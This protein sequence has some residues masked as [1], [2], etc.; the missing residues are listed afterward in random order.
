M[1]PQISRPTGIYTVLAAVGIVV[2]I[3]AIMHGIYIA[4]FRETAM[5]T[6]A[7]ITEIHTYSERHYDSDHDTVYHD[8]YVAFEIDD[9]EYAGKL[10][11]YSSGMKEG[12]KV[13]ILYAPENPNN[14]RYSK[15]YYMVTVS[16]I[17]FGTIFALIGIIPLVQSAS[18]KRLIQDGEKIM[19]KFQMITD[20][21]IEVNGNHT[22]IIVCEYRDHIFKSENFWTTACPSDEELE[23][24]LVPVYVQEDDY[25]NYYVDFDSFF[26]DQNSKNTQQ[27]ESFGNRI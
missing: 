19:A 10:N 23:G 21:N 3:I 5:E 8:V 16:F 12:G 27:H 6:T 20:G 2:I 7:V 22:R 14:F 25:S 24:T 13:Q 18:K 17:F 1:N 11:S 26:D 4:N 9:K 15:K